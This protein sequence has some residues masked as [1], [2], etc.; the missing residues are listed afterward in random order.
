VIDDQVKRVILEVSEI[1]PLHNKAGLEG[2]SLAEELF[3]NR[4]QVAVFDTGFHRTLPQ[5]AAI[6]PGPYQWYERGIRRYGFHGINHQ[7][8]AQRAARLLGRD[9]ASLK[10]VTCHLGNGCSLAAVENGK[11]IDTTMGFTPLEGLMMGTRA[12]SVDPGILI[13]LIETDRLAADRLNDVL[14]HDSGLVG[15]SGKSSD[16]R[17]ILDT[18]GAGHDQSARAQLAFDIFVHRLQSGIAAMCASLG[19][20]DAVVFS[21]GIGE[22]A[23]QVRSAA[24]TRLGF[25]GIRLDEARNLSAKADV[26]IS[27]PDGNV[28]VFVIRAQE[29]WAI[30]CESARLLRS[31]PTAVF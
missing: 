29:E 11:S 27:S 2:V 24:C 9:L 25:L 21:G 19:G 10:I 17:D 1:A 14:N 15:I 30:A 7:Y 3:P 20:L 4:V 26:E 31:R 28:R 13:H 12:G 23:P 6:Y 5:A 18:M 8:M 16:M 22:N